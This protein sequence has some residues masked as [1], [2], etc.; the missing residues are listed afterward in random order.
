MSHHSTDSRSRIATLKK[1]RVLLYFILLFAILLF[2]IGLVTVPFMAHIHGAV[3][4]WDTWVAR[5]LLTLAALLLAW[6]TGLYYGWR[7]KRLRRQTRK[8]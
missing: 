2:P 4:A 5:L 8:A 1:R 7:I 6:L 3:P